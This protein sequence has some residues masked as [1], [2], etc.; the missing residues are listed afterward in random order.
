MLCH[1]LFVFLLVSGTRF[2][3]L[4]LLQLFDFK[5]EEVV[6]SLFVLHDGLFDIVSGTGKFC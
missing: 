2:F 4:E 5:T 1:D 6:V 3:F